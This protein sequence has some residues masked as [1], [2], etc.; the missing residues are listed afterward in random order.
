MYLATI[1]TPGGTRAVRRLESD[2]A[3]R[4]VDLD[5]PDVNAV[6][7]DP[8]GL[9]RAAATTDGTTVDPA[10]ADFAAPV[11]PEKV[12]CV[13]HNYGDHIKRLGL[14]L[15]QHPRLSTK[16]ASSIIGPY[17][18]ITK[19]ADAKALD[20]AVE[21]V[22]VIGASI[23][24]PDDAEAA[25]AIA[26]FTVMND[27]TDRD[28]EFETHEWGLGNIW[29]GSSPLG[30]YLVTPDELP[31]GSAPTVAVRTTVDGK[32]VQSA[33]TADLHFSPVHLVRHVA[34]FMHLEPGD[35]IA[36]GSPSDPAH[37]HGHPH[38]IDGQVV[39]AAVEGIGECRNTVVDV[40]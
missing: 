8:D 14:T 15:P 30:P 27:V 13:R 40:D 12:V 31:G 38:L 33:N 34:R 37:E 21:L 9:T 17:D 18:P 39:V 32:T 23:R 26:G 7:T 16:F 36:T 25:A 22:I 24:H 1:R 6:L 11:T 5:Y 10:T 28:L 4:L 2:G 20:S 29:D 3:T 35:I 19:P